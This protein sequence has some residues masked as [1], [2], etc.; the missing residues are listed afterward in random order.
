MINGAKPAPIKLAKF[1]APPIVPR[2]CEGEISVA[3]T[4]V[5]EIFS[6]RQKIVTPITH[7]ITK[8]LSNKRYC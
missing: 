3:R 6:P 4:H 5:G 8:I 2:S 7:T 1:L